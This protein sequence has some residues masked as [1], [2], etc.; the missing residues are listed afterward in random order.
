LILLNKTLTIAIKYVYIKAGLKYFLTLSEIINLFKIVL[1]MGRKMGND[2]GAIPKLNL[3]MAVKQITDMPTGM[4]EK[5]IE[6]IA[7][8]EGDEFVK[9]ILA[10]LP[11]VKIAAILRQHDFSCPSIISWILTPK[12]VVNVLKVDPLFW[13]NIYDPSQSGNFFQIQNDALDLITSILEN[14]K[15]ID[16]QGEILRQISCDS[17]SLLY[18]YI[19]FIGWQIKKEQTLLIEDPDIDFG[20][21]DHLYEMIRWVAPYVAEKI[22]TFIYS[23]EI[24]LLDFITDLWS[25][26]FQCIAMEQDYMSV[27]NI[28]FLPVY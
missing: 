11:P 14:G 15:S 19:P 18:L 3:S 28:M 27:E 1:Y 23:A 5:A 24:S 8:R 17:L 13:K 20:T 4:A 9:D 16:N 25:D 26:A 21:A 10:H 2:Y 22:L 12:T 7:D 6:A